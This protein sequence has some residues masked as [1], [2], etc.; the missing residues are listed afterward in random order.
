[1]TKCNKCGKNISEYIEVCPNCG[2]NQESAVTPAFSESHA[3]VAWN[4][5]SVLVIIVSAIVFFVACFTA[6]CALNAYNAI[7]GSSV[8]GI[9]SILFEEYIAN[10]SM[11]PVIITGILS[12][13][14][15]IACIVSIIHCLVSHFRKK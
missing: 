5:K 7:I 11:K 12:A 15:S 2:H 6:I 1:M 4:K 3:S 13:I 10:D 9:G 14:I 8:L